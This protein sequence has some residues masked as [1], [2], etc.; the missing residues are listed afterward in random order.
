MK[1]S[2]FLLSLFALLAFSL[3]ACDE[4]E[5]N[6]AQCDVST[7][8]S[9]CLDGSH[10]MWCNNGSLIVT[11]CETGSICRDKDSAASCVTPQ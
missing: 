4:G 8:Q 3:T 2:L 10:F 1:H 11:A 9:E 7:Y 6:D 5:F